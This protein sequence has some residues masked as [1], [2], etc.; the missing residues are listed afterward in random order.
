MVQS[1]AEAKER[2]SGEKK[3]EKKKQIRL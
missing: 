2:T 1:G 3:R